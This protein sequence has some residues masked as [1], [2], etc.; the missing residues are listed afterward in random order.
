[1]KTNIMV[2]YRYV[3][4]NGYEH[5]KYKTPFIKPKIYM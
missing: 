1:M 2:E 4:V 5:L 3:I